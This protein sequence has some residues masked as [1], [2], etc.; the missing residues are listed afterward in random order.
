MQLADDIHRLE[1][2]I[3][4]DEQ[5]ME[6]NRRLLVGVVKAEPP[7]VN[8]EVVRG[9]LRSARDLV[10]HNQAEAAQPLLRQAQEGLNAVRQWLAVTDLAVSPF[11]LRTYL[12]KNRLGGD[13]LR[14]L[15]RYH[16]TKHPHAENDRDKLDY[17][18]TAYFSPAISDAVPDRAALA[19]QL[20]ALFANL[21]AAPPLSDPAQVMLHEFESLMAMVGDFND[22]D[23]LVQA[24]MVERVRALKTNLAEEFY[25]ARVLT[26]VVRFNLVFRRHFEFLFHQQLQ[27]VREETRQEFE[28]AW[29]LLREM[30]EAFESL[31]LGEAEKAAPAPAAETKAPAR[32]PARLGRP[33]EVLDE[34]PPIDHLVRRGQERTK[35]NELRGIIGRL[36]R[37]VAKLPPELAEGGRVAFRLRQ[38][39]LQ[40]ED[41]ER[42]AFDA[43]AQAAAPE[44]TRAIQNCLGV[45]AWIEEELARY[46]ETRDDRY[47]W[48][49]HVDLL[50]YAVARAVELLAGIRPLFRADAAKGEAAWLESLLATTRRVGAALKRVYPLFNEPA[51]G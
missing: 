26:T 48:K 14:A 32:G 13:L 49:A 21:P 29:A 10:K 45:V 2:G 34:R 47:L 39:E 30:E 16:I 40:L 25:V 1:E 44:S 28:E 3:A 51:Q 17:L 7:P 24:R 11:L 41:W 36:S 23:Q 31:A 46:E 22:F 42:E 37:Y 4:Q 50:S 20:E 43:A 8:L 27:R 18:L 15:I 5:V 33:Q 12:E 19:Q 35:E 38:G 6:L 9:A